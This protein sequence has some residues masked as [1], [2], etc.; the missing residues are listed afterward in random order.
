M[1]RMS[2]ELCRRRTL[3]VRL[4]STV[5]KEMTAMSPLGL[6]SLD[7][8]DDWWRA[9]KTEDSEGVYSTYLNIE[10]AKKEALCRELAAAARLS[11]GGLDRGDASWD[12]TF[13]SEPRL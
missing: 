9:E 5:S 10:T 13:L 2:K 11:R 4:A 6:L 3:G 7:G 8:R 12:L 1:M